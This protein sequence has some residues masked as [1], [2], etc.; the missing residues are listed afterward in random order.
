MKIYNF[1]KLIIFIAFSV[2]LVV[3][4]NELVQ[5]LHYFIGALVFT[6][7]LESNVVLAVVAKKNCIRS[8]K[9]SFSLFEMVVGLT[10]FFAVRNFT[11]VCVMWA[12]W[13]MLRQS[14]DIHEVLKGEV[15]GVVAVI[16]IIQSVVSVVFS[17]ML[18]LNPTH[19]HAVTHIYLLIA[20][21]LVISLPP[22]IDELL[23]KKIKKRK[24]NV[25]KEEQTL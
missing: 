16:F 24:D 5:D 25:E 14:L 12:V 22:V 9:F 17:I 11:H 7:G 15:K 4:R 23:I 8:I 2:L 13:S 6:Y 18:I 19:H 20:E 10:I 3:F 1:I 21:L